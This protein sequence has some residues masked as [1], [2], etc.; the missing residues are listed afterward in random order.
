[1]N[2]QEEIE[3]VI[4]QIYYNNETGYGSIKKTY[5]ESKKIMKSITLEKVK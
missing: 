2:T 4:R 5:D 1:M 3:R